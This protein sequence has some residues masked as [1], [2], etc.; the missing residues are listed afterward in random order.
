MPSSAKVGLI[1]AAQAR[2][3]IVRRNN[4]SVHSSNRVARTLSVEGAM[5][6]RPVGAEPLQAAQTKD[7]YEIGEIPPLGHV[8]TS[9]YAWVIRKERHGPP[10][11][12]CRSRSC[13]P[14]RSTVTTSSF[15]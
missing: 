4:E 11:N 2:W 10:E 8:P 13:R 6:T 5:I 9:M 1:F 15:S 3:L 12:P 14:G 7:L